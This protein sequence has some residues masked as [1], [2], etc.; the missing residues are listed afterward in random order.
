MSRTALA[1]LTVLVALAVWPAPSAAAAR[2]SPG[3]RTTWQIQFSGR[4]NPSIDATVFDL[5]MF[6]TAPVTV[7][8]LHEEGRR[9]VCYIN[10]GAWEDWRPDASRYPGAVK[11]R[12]LDGWPGERWLD[13]RRIDLLGP[14]LTDRLDRCRDKGFDGVEFDNVDGYSNDSGFPLTAADQLTFDKWLAARA[15]E[16]GLAVGLKNTLNLADELEPHFDFAI[17][18]QCFQYRECGLAAPFFEAGKSVIDVEYSVSRDRFCAKAANLGIAA[19]RKRL[20]LD[21]WR[22]ACP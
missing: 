1:A 7:A 12:A 15:H 18:E 4:L 20:S 17:L 21:A 22:R 2:W 19:M 6:D 11:G 9:V 8:T 16:L 14:I 5:D 10:A 3:T 13:I